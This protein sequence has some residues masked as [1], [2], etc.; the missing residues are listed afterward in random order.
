MC[1][2]NGIH[3]VTQNMNSA[4]ESEVEVPKACYKASE[5]ICHIVVAIS[6]RT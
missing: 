5:P 2:N 3:F 6:Y 4:A 1:N